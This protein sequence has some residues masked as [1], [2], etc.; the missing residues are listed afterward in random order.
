M[1]RFAVLFLEFLLSPAVG[2]GVNPQPVPAVRG[3][4]GFRRY[5]VPSNTEP[6]RG[7]VSEYSAKV[8]VNKQICDVLQ[9]DELGSNVANRSP[10]GGPEVSRVVLS[11]LFPGGRE[12]LTREARG[13]EI[14][15]S[16]PRSPVE[17]VE[18]VPDRGV[19][20]EAVFDPLTEDLLTILFDLDISDG[21]EPSDEV[22]KGEGE[23]SDS[24][25]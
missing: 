14:H 8:S 24:G 3:A 16:T 12:R 5:A 18:V 10:D 9:E 25:T 23:S 4:D 13:D 19:V 1:L 2:V 7:Q 20:E 21:L 17:G 6:A 22:S 11:G 15:E